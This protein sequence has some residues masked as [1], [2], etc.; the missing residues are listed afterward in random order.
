MLPEKSFLNLTSF[1][2]HITATH[3]RQ[4]H[5]CEM[6]LYALPNDFIKTRSSLSKLFYLDLNKTF[7]DID[8]C[9]R[10]FNWSKYLLLSSAHTKLIVLS[11]TLAIVEYWRFFTFSYV[12]FSR[13]WKFTWLTTCHYHNRICF[14]P[15]KVNFYWAN[16]SEAIFK[17]DPYGLTTG[18]Y[19][20]AKLNFFSIKWK[21]YNVHLASFC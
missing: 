14:S 7:T 10:D 17:I 20:H 4:N 12:N 21:L 16:I 9:Y 2:S 5:K 1:Y 11:T 15:S 19:T 13:M 6:A 3:Y 8:R 18:A